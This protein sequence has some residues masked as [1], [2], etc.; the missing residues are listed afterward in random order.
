MRRFEI[1]LLLLVIATLFLVGAGKRKQIKILSADKWIGTVTRI[2]TSGGKGKLV[3]YNNGHEEVHRYDVYFSYHT[4][5]NFINS[6]GTVSRADTSTKWEKDSLFYSNPDVYT[7]T[8][9]TE[10]INRNGK[11]GFVQ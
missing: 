9:T 1:S 11:G 6:K 5:A 10:K 4:D 2:K 7:I 3:T 8:E